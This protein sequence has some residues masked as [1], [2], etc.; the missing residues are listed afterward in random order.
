M[1]AVMKLWEQGQLTW[2]KPVQEYVPQFPAKYFDNQEVCRRWQIKAELS[3]EI[4]WKLFR[5]L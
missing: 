2:D 5:S 3:R 1:T 4:I